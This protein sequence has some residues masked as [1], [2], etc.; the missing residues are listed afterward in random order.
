MC[1][2]CVE[3]RTI[4]KKSYLTRETKNG[5]NVSYSHSYILLVTGFEA[6]SNHAANILT[7][8]QP[9]TTGL[10]RKQTLIMPLYLWV[11]EAK[12]EKFHFRMARTE[13]GF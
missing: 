11:Q 4:F 8:N 13:T 3:K 10:T 5:N 6:L 7:T 12:N 1:R 9:K 2:D